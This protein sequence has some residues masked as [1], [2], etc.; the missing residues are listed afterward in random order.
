[1]AIP[2]RLREPPREIAVDTVQPP[3]VAM[4]RKVSVTSLGR[5]PLA[6]FFL[7]LGW[8]TASAACSR[9]IGDACTT[10]SDCDP[11]R[12]TR[13]CDL[14]QPGGYCVIEGC[15]ARSCPEDSFCVRFFPTLYAS[16][17]CEPPCSPAPCVPVAAC[18]A[19]EECVGPDAEAVCVRRSLEKRV[20]VQSCGGDG[21]CRGGYVCRATGREGAIALTLTAG[22]TP[23]Y[24]RPKP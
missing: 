21:D 23:K 13:T 2:L 8:A 24:C 20:C 14:S 5:F 15:D 4:T 12:G 10:S 16:A 3:H 9:K 11:S 18:F 17:V 1:M 7:L 6:L 22:A 19:D